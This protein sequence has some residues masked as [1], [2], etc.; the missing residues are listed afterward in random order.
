MDHIKTPEELEWSFLWYWKGGNAAGCTWTH[1]P[2]PAAAHTCVC[3]HHPRLA[4]CTLLLWRQNFTQ[5]N[6]LCPWSS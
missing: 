5:N 3:S 2:L 1:H 4:D 6:E